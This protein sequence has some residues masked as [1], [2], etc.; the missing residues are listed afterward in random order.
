MTEM[1]K[2][3]LWMSLLGLVLGVGVGLL[4]HLSIPDGSLARPEQRPFLL[5]YLLASGLYGAVNMGTSALYDVE[6]WSILRCT[7]AH[8]AICLGS[9]AL[10][11]GTLILAGWMPMP[12]VGW[13]AVMLS[14][15]VAVYC[16]I[17]LFQYLA[18]RRKVKNMNAQLRKWKNSRKK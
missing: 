15:F 3:A 1:K 11:F 9:S 4:F 18:Y 6:D 7:A 16:L 2:R 14:A 13:W 17:W 12:S 8:F 10:F 5:L